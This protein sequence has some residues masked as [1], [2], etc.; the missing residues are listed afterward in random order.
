MVDTPMAS[1]PSMMAIRRSA[2]GVRVVAEVV[3]DLGFKQ[4]QLGSLEGVGLGAAVGGCQT[5]VQV[6]NGGLER[7]LGARLLCGL[8]GVPSRHGG[9]AISGR[10]G[11][12][13]GQ[14][15]EL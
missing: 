5:S 2:C 8:L 13:K 10:L 14:R 12:V 3:V 11:V 9:V 15:L 1:D 6:G 4:Q 7:Q